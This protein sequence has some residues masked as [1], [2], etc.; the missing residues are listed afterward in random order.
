MFERGSLYDGVLLV[1][2]DLVYMVYIIYRND[3]KLLRKVN[4][5]FHSHTHA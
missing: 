2:D 3:G 4:E 1:V 5:L